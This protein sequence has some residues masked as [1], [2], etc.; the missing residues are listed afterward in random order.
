MDA[1]VIQRSMVDEEISRLLDSI[2]DSVLVLKARL[3]NSNRDSNSLGGISTLGRRSKTEK[4]EGVMDKRLHR[5]KSDRLIWGVCGGLA[6]HLN[7]DPAIVRLIA[8]LSIFLSGFGIMAYIILAAVLPLEGSASAEPKDTIRENVQE[9]KE[10]ATEV[11]R[12]IQSTFA[13]GKSTPGKTIERRH[14]A[15]WVLGIIFIILGVLFLLGNLNIFWWFHRDI[16]WPVILLVIGVLILL[17][18]R[19]RR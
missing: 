15:L 10:T 7:V 12:G 19:R 6:K 3:R 16:L 1:T 11:G 9:M 5:S 17:A 13:S 8:V 4:G 2:L 18:A 14:N